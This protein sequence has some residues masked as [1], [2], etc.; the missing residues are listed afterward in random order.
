MLSYLLGITIVVIVTEVVIR[1][2]SLRTIQTLIRLGRQS[3]SII[4]S[5]KYSDDEKQTLLLSITK[6][7]MSGLL[8]LAFN[9]A[10][11]LLLFLFPIWFFDNH[12]KPEPPLYKLFTSSQGLV[13]FTIICIFYG[14]FRH[15]FS[16]Q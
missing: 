4:R 6:Q 15:R 7:N 2:R 10:T 14:Y 16:N 11:M 3:V 1:G 8:K 5:K 12:L 9:L 13:T